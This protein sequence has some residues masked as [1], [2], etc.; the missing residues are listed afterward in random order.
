[1]ERKCV[2]RVK[3]YSILIV[4]DNL[5]MRKILTGHLSD[6]G[7]TVVA[8]GNGRQALESL[9]HSHFSIVITDLV[10]PEMGGLELCRTIRE[11]D[12]GG[13]TYVVMLTQDSDEMMRGLKPADEFGEAVCAELTMRLK[14]ADRIL[15]RSSPKATKKGAVRHIYQS[16]QPR[17]S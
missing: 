11:R 6:L 8:V 12:F 4:E 10:M 16:L 2:E 15:S 7:H 5:L 17:L 14:T 1:M 3:S 13:Y 9:E